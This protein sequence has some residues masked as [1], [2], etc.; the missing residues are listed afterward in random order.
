MIRV[1]SDTFLT[2]NF[3]KVSSSHF[4]SLKG[5]YFLHE[6]G[7]SSEA[8]EILE[9]LI[10]REPGF[11]S[12]YPLLGSILE[13]SGRYERAGELYRKALDLPGINP[14]ESDYFSRKAEQMQAM[15]TDE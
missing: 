7:R 13:A 11:S 8:V 6:K 10:K 2:S 1:V 3:R 5:S 15:K 12:A 9:G 14:G 4:R